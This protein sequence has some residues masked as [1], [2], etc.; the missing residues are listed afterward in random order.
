MNEQRAGKPMASPGKRVQTRTGPKARA[1]PGV[2]MSYFSHLHNSDATLRARPA[3]SSNGRN[4]RL[5][6]RVL[7]TAV[8]GE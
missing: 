7:V 2:P 8:T 6:Q 4:E 5:P 3:A 1:I